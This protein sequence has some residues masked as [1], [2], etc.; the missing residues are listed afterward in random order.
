MICCRIIISVRSFNLQHTTE[1]WHRI[2]LLLSKTEIQ[3][4]KNCNRKII[5]CEKMKVELVAHDSRTE[6]MNIMSALCVFVL[7]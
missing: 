2:V 3:P 1:K 4:N 6:K 5:R 7:F